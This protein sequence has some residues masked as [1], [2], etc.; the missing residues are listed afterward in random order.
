[1]REMKKK[2]RLF[3]AAI[4]AIISLTQAGTVEAAEAPYTSITYDKDDHLVSTMD[5]YIPS[6][7][8]DKFGEE[9]LKKPSDLFIHGEELY[10]ADTG[11]GRILICDLDGNYIGSITE[12]LKSPTGVFVADNGKVY[13]ADPGAKQIL[14]YNRNQTLEKTFDTPVSPLFGANAKYAPS[15]LVVNSAGTVYALSEGNASGIMTISDYG[16]FYGYFGANDT[17]I[18]LANKIKRILFTEEQLSS[19]QKNVPASATNLD[20]DSTGLVYTVTQ[21]LGSNGLKKYNMAGSNM[22]ENAWADSLVIDVAVGS[23]DNIFTISKQGFIVEYTKEGELLFYF[24][25]KDDGKN[26][27][28][29]FTNAVAIDVDDENHIYV[30]DT[31]R[32]DITVFTQTEYAA[33]VHEALNMYQDGFY[34]ESKEPWETV[35]TRNSLFDFAYRGIAKAQ[36]KLED[37]PKAMNAARLGGSMSTYSSAF[38]QIRNVWLRKHIV[39]IFWILI[40]FGILKWVWKKFGDK[41]FGIR[42]IKRALQAFREKKHVREFRFLKYVLKNPADAFYGIKKE[43]KTSVLTATFIYL[44]IF[45]IYVVNK[46]YCGFLFK[47][48]PD[49]EY[50]LLGDVLKVPGL[51][52][53]FVICCN[54]ICSIRDGEATFKQTYMAFAYCFMPYIFLKPAAFLLSH[55]LT[56]NETFLITFLNFTMTAGTLALIVVMIR[57]IQCFSYKETFINILLTLFTM[58]VLVAAGVIVFALFKQVVDFVIGIYKEGYYRGR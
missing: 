1:M 30:L 24:S 35:L 14:V 45:A 46:Y 51:M 52:L 42:H 33:T 4:L 18:S 29:L 43:N 2:Y 31:D 58:L 6:A 50:D 17:E 23:I 8:W 26:R 3:L 15:K 19:M 10:I 44:L 7:L 49:G 27:M 5:G 54:M 56:Y 12:G 47:G 11:N 20:I 25:G 38:W 40:A 32:N 22:F 21:G 34:L 55:V 16:D 37:Y 13:V 28:G 57:E 53:L 39:D 41:I 48:I 36:Y 9:T